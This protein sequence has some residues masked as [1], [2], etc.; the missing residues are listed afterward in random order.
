LPDLASFPVVRADAE[1]LQQVLLNLLSNAVKFTHDGGRIAIEGDPADEAGKV[2]IRVIDTGRGI[3][4][5]KLNTIFDPFIQVDASHSRE[6]QGTGLG[7]TISR[8]LA[9][10][11]GG[12][13][14]VRSE[15]GVGSSFMLTLNG[16]PAPRA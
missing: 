10:G 1:K 5:D 11:M 13:L 12:D 16:A 8:D 3:P 9:R 14:Q 4:A 2:S 6:S 15:L 7:L